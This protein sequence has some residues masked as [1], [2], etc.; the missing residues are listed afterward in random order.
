MG[1][2]AILLLLVFCTSIT[3]FAQESRQKK[4]EAQ[5]KQLQQEIKQINT[6]LFS[7]T[8]NSSQ[9]MFHCWV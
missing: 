6:L 2:K 3:G 1:K 9:I 5:R 7:N 8:K 4:L